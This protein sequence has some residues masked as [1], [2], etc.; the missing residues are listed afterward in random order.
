MEHCDNQTMH[1]NTHW[2]TDMASIPTFLRLRM[3]YTNM[4]DNGIF[5]VNDV[6]L[7]MSTE[8]KEL[9][10]GGHQMMHY[11]CTVPKEKGFE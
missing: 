3:E 2:M 4:D 10:V 8:K 1:I 7:Y 9:G 6:I 5:V 11:H